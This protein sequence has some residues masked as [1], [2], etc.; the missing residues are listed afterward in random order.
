MLE[1]LKLG[2]SQKIISSDS[3]IVQSEEKPTQQQ[4]QQ[5][6]LMKELKQ[7]LHESQNKKPEQKSSSSTSSD[8]EYEQMQHYIEQLRLKPANDLKAE[9]TNLRLPTKGR[10]P[11]LVDR[12][13]RYYVS[14]DGEGFDTD[15][16]NDEDM[17]G[18]DVFQKPAIS[19]PSS[20]SLN[21][22]RPMSFAGIS[23]L[24][25][26]AS[27]ALHQAF[28]DAEP[29]P[30]QKVAI[31]KLFYAQ[32]SALLHGEF[33]VHSFAKSRCKYDMYSLTTQSSYHFYSANWLREDS[34]LHT[35]NHRKS[36]EGS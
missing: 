16:D 14:Q 10:K 13:A 5:Q 35:P 1:G 23:K 34:N 21:L 25:T 12:L 2:S 3:Q 28:G 24:S 18:E 9:L 32:Q 26:V 19:A 7:S 15:A 31:P 30:I 17:D 11:D 6:K 8:T 4:M 22:D 29:T 33:V 20:T 36:M 27:N